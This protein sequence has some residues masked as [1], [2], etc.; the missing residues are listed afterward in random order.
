MLKWRSKSVRRF[1]EG[2]DVQLSKLYH[3]P[4]LTRLDD[5][6]CPEEKICHISYDWNESCRIALVR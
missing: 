4:S 1:L 3:S 5:N 6:E 2:A